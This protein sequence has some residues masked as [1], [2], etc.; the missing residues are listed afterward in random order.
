VD[1]KQAAK[2]AEISVSLM[3]SLIAEGRVAHRRMG[4]Q[5]RRGKIVITESDLQKFLDSMKVETYSR[6]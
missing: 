4:R 1:V 6:A 5:G 2:R 3:Y